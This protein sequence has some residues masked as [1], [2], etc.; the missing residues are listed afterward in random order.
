MKIH[1]MSLAEAFDS[2]KSGPA[3]LA[4]GVCG[5]V[6]ACAVAALLL[7]ELRKWIVRRANI[8]VSGAGS[9]VA[10]VAKLV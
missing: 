6:T 2:L 10:P 7:E 5:F 9:T 3:G 1:Q 8:G 4:A